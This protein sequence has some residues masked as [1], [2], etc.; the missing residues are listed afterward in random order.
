M[1]NLKEKRS[2]NRSQGMS[3]LGGEAVPWQQ[4]LSKGQKTP[5]AGSKVLMFS[6]SAQPWRETFPL[7]PSLPL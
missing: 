2:K 5:R 7:I 1:R 6:G 4:G 3:K